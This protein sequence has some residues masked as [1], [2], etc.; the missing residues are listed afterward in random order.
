[1]QKFRFFK[2]QIIGSSGLVND[3]VTEAVHE[4]RNEG[5]SEGR[6]EA[7]N[8]AVNEAVNGAVNDTVNE[9]VNDTVNCR[10][11]SFTTLF[12]HHSVTLPPVGG[13]TVG[14]KIWHLGGA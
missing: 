1:M 8:E 5:R 14:I 2:A 12:R 6:N 9:A 11:I 4:G 7:I 3:P 10:Q 13:I